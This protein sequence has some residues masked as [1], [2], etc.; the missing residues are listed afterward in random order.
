M[1]RGTAKV[2]SSFAARKANVLPMAARSMSTLEKKGL[3]D[4][5][6]YFAQ[7]DADKIKAMKAKFETVVAKG[8][9]EEIE[10]LMEV[11]GACKLI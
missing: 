1:I 11:L 10:E 3:S 7:A 8:D 5:A 9:V 6:R 2:L 4:E